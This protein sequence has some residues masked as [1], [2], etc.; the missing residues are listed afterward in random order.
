MKKTNKIKKK[1]IAGTTNLFAIIHLCLI[2]MCVT[3]MWVITEQV[4]GKIDHYGWKTPLQVI[5]II[6][7]GIAGIGLYICFIPTLSEMEK[8]YIRIGKIRQNGEL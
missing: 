2:V 7:A 1:Y 3:T 8:Q 4:T 5:L 6:V